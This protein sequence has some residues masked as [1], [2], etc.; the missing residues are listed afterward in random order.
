MN[1]EYADFR[2][3]KV[4]WLYLAFACCMATLT[5][6]EV[7]LEGSARWLFVI[8]VFIWLIARLSPLCRPTLWFE[9]IWILSGGV[10]TAVCFSFQA[11]LVQQTDH[12][13]LPIGLVITLSMAPLFDHVKVYTVGSLM[14]WWSTFV[15]VKPTYPGAVET[16]YASLMCL[17][18]IG[19][20]VFL[21][22][23]MA[24]TRLENARLFEQMR[25]QATHDA[26]TGLLNRRALLDEGWKRDRSPTSTARVYFAM[27]DV[28]D[29]KRINDQHGHAV[30]DAVLVAVAQALR[31]ATPGGLAGRLGG[32]EFGA[33]FEAQPQALEDILHGMLA[34]VQQLAQEPIR[35]T[36]SI[37]VA[38]HGAGEALNRLLQRADEALYRA[39]R[40]GKNRFA[41]ALDEPQT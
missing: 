5:I 9:S 24:L 13:F 35:P 22:H 21:C 38:E 32:E 36:I 29:F 25:H 23:I 1:V 17:G 30:G 11:T 20:A 18:S 34:R 33:W 27:V 26:L 8:P 41:L 15:I 10:L 2:R 39:K 3:L 14:I 37:G 19:V 12:W 7:Y 40:Q 4:A 31:D 28:D 16:A 6:N